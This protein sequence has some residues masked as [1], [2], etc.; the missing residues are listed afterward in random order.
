MAPAAK[1]LVL[2][3]DQMQLGQPIQ[4]SHPGESGT[5]ALEY[6]LQDHRTI[7][8]WLGVFLETSWRLHPELCR[9]ISG[10]V[11]DDKLASEPSAA[12]RVVTRSP[13]AKLAAKEAGI[14]FVPAPHEGNEQ[15]SDE[16]VAVIAAI[17]TELRGR[18]LTG[19]SGER[20]KRASGLD[21]RDK[22]DVLVVAPYN[23]QVRAVKAA[24]PGVEVGSVDR[25]QGQEAAVV[26]VSMCAS[27][28][29]AGGRGIEF[30]FSPNRLNVALSRAQSLAIVV[31]CPELGRTRVTSV[32]QMKLVNLFC[33]IVAEGG[34]SATPARSS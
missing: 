23:M 7:P 24:L 13:S 1:N 6:L 8:P 10:A 2:L 5:S 21:E 22:R 4:G 26:I 18:E 27:S 29:D 11:Y 15:A 17:L 3:G 16:E 14:V 33:R 19:T 12:T 9:F 28:G 31:G 34:Q 20:A 32:G 30:L 25:F